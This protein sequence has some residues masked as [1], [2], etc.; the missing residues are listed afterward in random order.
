MV[1]LINGVA[2]LNLREIV[3]RKIKCQK[4][5]PLIALTAENN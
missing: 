2:N 5:T 3:A 4:R 1:A